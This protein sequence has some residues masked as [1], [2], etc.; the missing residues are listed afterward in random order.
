MDRFEE[1]SPGFDDAV[2]S[3]QIRQG[4]E[5]CRQ[6]WQ[7]PEQVTTGVSFGKAHPTADVG[8]RHS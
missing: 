2:K 8:A 5:K 7:S 6:T 3:K 4:T 1:G